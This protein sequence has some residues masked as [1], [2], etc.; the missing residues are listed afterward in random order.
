MRLPHDTAPGAAD[1]LRREPTSSPSVALVPRPSGRRRAGASLPAHSLSEC[2]RPAQGARGA[3]PRR[4]PAIHRSTVS[5]RW[6]KRQAAA[7]AGG[8]GTGSAAALRSMADDE[9]RCRLALRKRRGFSGFICDQRVR[10]ASCDG[11]W[12]RVAQ[13]PT[14]PENPAV[15]EQ[16]TAQGSRRCQSGG[17]GPKRISEQ[18]RRL[19]A[20]CLSRQ[21]WCRR[22]AY[23]GTRATTTALARRVASPALAAAEGWARD[24]LA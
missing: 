20:G 9:R 18:E 12:G 19:R 6:R 5:A 17:I 2:E 3:M 14:T 1:V 21:R 13:C 16:A 10:L 4:G 22:S 23:T 11:Y 15:V 24:R 7:T 8:G